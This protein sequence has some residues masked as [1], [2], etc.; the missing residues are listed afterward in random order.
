MSASLAPNA[1]YML[2]DIVNLSTLI[3]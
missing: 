2:P 1:I 3:I